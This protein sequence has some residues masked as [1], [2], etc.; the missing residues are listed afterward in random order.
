MMNETKFFSTREAASM[1]RIS[2][3]KLSRLLWQRA[4]IPEPL[5]GPDGSFLWTRADAE[6]ASWVIH[7]RPLEQIEENPS[8][9]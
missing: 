5:R 6:R 8:R 3:I 2:A 9:D 1:L 7:R 4:I